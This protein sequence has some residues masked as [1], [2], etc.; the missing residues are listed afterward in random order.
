MSLVGI[1][2]EPFEFVV[3]EG[4]VREFSAAVF[5]PL[6]KDE[7]AFVPPTFPMLG[8]ADFEH[9]FLF[10]VLHLD[11]TRSLNAGQEYTYTRPLR[12]GDRLNCVGRV[13]ED[14]EKKGK[15]GGTMR[16]V[17]IDVEMRCAETDNLVVTSRA[18]SVVTEGAPK[19]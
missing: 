8:V 10:D 17:V 1:E 5:N 12:P 13:S 18:T 14:Y 3:E 9:H 2:S 11:P 16:F 6:E 15:R 7:P 19:A 4:K